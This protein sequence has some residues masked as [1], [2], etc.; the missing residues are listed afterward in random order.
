MKSFFNKLTPAE[1]RLVVIVGI[2]VFAVINIWWIIPMFGEYGKFEKKRGDT[3]RLIGT[4]KAEIARKGAYE[5]LIRELSSLGGEVASEAAALRLLDEVNSQIALSGISVTSIS[6]LNR[7]A[8]GGKTNAFF[9][10]ASVNV[11]F[12]AGEKELINFLYQLADKQFLIRAKSLNVQPDPQGRM[13]LQGSVTLVK[14]YQRKAPPKAVPTT[15]KTA[16]ATNAATKPVP[17]AT[18]APKSAPTNTPAAPPKK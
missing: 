15:P 12:S 7:V 1:R 2:V 4:Y 11:S 18:T 6:P 13:R 10:E 17:K 3:L 14:S 9:E 16:P 8:Y 5:K